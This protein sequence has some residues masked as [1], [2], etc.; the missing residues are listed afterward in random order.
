MGDPEITA[1]LYCNFSYLYWEGCVICSIFCGNLWTTQYDSTPNPTSYRRGRRI[2]DPKHFQ[3]V[4]NKNY[5][6]LSIIVRINSLYCMS[7]KA[8]TIFYSKLLY[9]MGKDFCM[10]AQDQFYI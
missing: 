4:W 8:C 2:Q 5:K 10:Y 6:H 9:K 1:N 7:K 3:T